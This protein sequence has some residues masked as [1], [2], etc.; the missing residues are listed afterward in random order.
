MAEPLAFAAHGEV[1]RFEFPEVEG[2]A[3]DGCGGG[4]MLTARQLEALHQQAY[5]EGYES[6]QAEGYAAGERR[7]TEDM[8]ART[9]LLDTTLRQL[10][11][12]LAE[13]D[14][15]LVESVAELAL[16][17][18]RHLVRRELKAAPG[19][20]VAVVR[21]AMRHL[22]VASRGTRLRL[23]PDDVEIVR[24]ALA[25]GSGDTAWRLDPDPL[26]ARGGCVVETETSRIDATVET[27]LAAIASRMFGGER[28][29]DREAST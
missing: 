13:L 19:E 25:I 14:D 17:I 18:A 26:I 10:S 20:V 24:S 5:R 28:G 15:T 2:I 27:R 16:L 22:P 1:A 12:P 23:N 11:A 4:A 7:A 8:R 6:G 21:E 9:Q 29:S 3:V